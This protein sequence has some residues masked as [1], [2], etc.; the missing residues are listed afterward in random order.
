MIV[1]KCKGGPSTPDWWFLTLFTSLKWGVFPLLPPNVFF[2]MEWSPCIPDPQLH[3]RS[4]WNPAGAEP[5]PVWVWKNPKIPASPR[6]E[7]EPHPAHGLG[8]PGAEWQT[9]THLMRFLSLPLP[10]LPSLSNPQNSER[11]I[12][13]NKQIRNH[14]EMQPPVWGQSHFLHP[15]LYW[16]S[17][18]SSSHELIVNNSHWSTRFIKHFL[19]Y[20]TEV[21]SGNFNHTKIILNSFW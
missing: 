13:Q 17:H 4:P 21:S 5:N 1:S 2:S 15:H 8:L 7:A 19:I 16:E 6:R 10:Q 14:P 20:Q 12:C 11:L 3:M 18:V 9:A